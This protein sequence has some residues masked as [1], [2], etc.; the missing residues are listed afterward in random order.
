MFTYN[1]FVDNSCHLFKLCVIFFETFTIV[2]KFLSLSQCAN[3]RLKNSLITRF[4]NKN[5]KYDN[6]YV[7]KIEMSIKIL[8]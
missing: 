2:S 7:Y 8:A 5:M 4:E 1:F 6:F 3:L